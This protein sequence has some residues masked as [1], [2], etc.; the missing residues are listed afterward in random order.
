MEK[1]FTK[2]D[3]EYIKDD[4]DAFAFAGIARLVKH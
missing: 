2:T 1:F 3:Y 4:E